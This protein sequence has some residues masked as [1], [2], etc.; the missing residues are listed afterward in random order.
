ML[1]YIARRSVYTVVVLFV[2]SIIIFWGL[3]IAPG[4][5]ETT[6]YNPQASEEAKA[7]LRIK[8]GLDEPV[9]VQYAYFLRDLFKGDF[10]ESIKSGQPIPDLVKEYGKNSLILVS[11]A[12]I[13]TF[14]LAIPLGVLAAIKRD[15]WIDHGLMGFASI[16]MGIPNFLLALILI[17]IF[18]VSLQWLPI[19]GTGSFKHL[20]LPVIAL[21]MELVA[22]TLR[23]TRSSMLEELQLDYVRALR[24]KG[25]R[26]Y[27]VTGKRVLRNALLPLIS[28]SGIMIGALI[29]YTAIVEIIFRWPGLGLLLLNS[30]LQ[31][32]YP[33]ALWLALFLTAIVILANFVANIGYAFA[34]PRI[35][36]AT[37]EAE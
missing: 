22:V 37:R 32:D 33:V 36:L 1:S 20:I 27:A 21:S 31:R 28:L 4:S 15:T 30:V 29:G 5:P 7:A 13:F 16:S 11:A 17:L 25:L 23:L 34:D 26:G 35:R 8:F 14:A 18:A 2:A 19:S 10:G 6:L 3:R 24:A 12:A 9:A